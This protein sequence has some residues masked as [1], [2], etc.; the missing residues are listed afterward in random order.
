MVKMTDIAAKAGVSQATVSLVLNN[1]TDGVRISEATRQRVIAAARDLGY[2]RN[3]VARA[4]VTGKTRVI[5]FAAGRHDCEE[6]F[7]ALAGV[8]EGAFEGEYSV[9]IFPV[10]SVRPDYDLGRAC[11]EQRL[12]G[13]VAQDLPDRLTAAVKANLD[14]FR[15]P[16]VTMGGSG[17]AGG[18]L[19]VLADEV[20]GAAEALEHLKKHGHSRIGWVEGGPQA[21]C[22]AS[23]REQIFR[24]AAARAGVAIDETLMVKGGAEM[25]DT[26]GAA[27]KL[28]GSGAPP[29]A[30]LCCCDRSALVAI[31][32][33]RQCGLK[34]PGDISVVGFG[35]MT[36]CDL[37]DP[38][39]SSVA[40][41][42]WR[43]GRRAAAEIIELSEKR[44][45]NGS[46]PAREITLPT[47]FVDRASTGPARG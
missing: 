29:T 32:A 38:P 34:V 37:S 2:Q 36:F 15:I 42:Y 30:I 31:R 14:R 27:K 4:M 10:E 18:I 40:I 19:H 7:R 11:V 47:G 35:G 33:A 16:M 25:G 6:S 21:S 1:R 13:L 5:G 46:G 8:T 23:G 39:L 24:D 20:L 44:D 9:K 3:E 26:E 28:F 17:D 45:G 43:L 12:A 22:L 41:P